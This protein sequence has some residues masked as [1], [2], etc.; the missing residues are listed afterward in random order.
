MS[1]LLGQISSTMWI[2]EHQVN[3]DDKLFLPAGTF[4]VGRPVGKQPG[5]DVLIENDNS[6]SR[7]H[8]SIEVQPDSG[9]V[10]LTGASLDV[11]CCLVLGT[12]YQACFCRPVIKVRLLCRP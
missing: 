4:K 10:T 9:S 12:D 11:L 2:L 8:A 6:I 1:D 3:T 7:M 5:A